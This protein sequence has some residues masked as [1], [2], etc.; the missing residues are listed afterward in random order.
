MKIVIIEDEQITADDLALSIRKVEPLAQIIAILKS[1]RESI[2]FFQDNSIKIDLIFSDIQLSD[3][4]SFEIFNKLSI[5]APII[6]CT[7]YDEYALNAFKV[8][9]IHYLLKPFTLKTVS[10]AIIKF[11]VLSSNLSGNSLQYHEI[12]EILKEGKSINQISI[13]VYQKDK[14]LPVP[15]NNIAIAYIEN[16]LTYIITF[17]QDKFPVNKSLEEIETL[18]GNRFF[19]AN[20]QYL[21]NRKVIK[22]STQYFARKILIN[23]SFP[24]ENRIIVSKARASEFLNWLSGN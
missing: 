20:R 9:G 22:D 17:N 18:T 8:N 15:L 7:A 23:L 5:N 21:V 10:E 14:I 13:L 11:K 12:L 24:F 6:F 16:E 3:G 4:L 1:V 19:R 2:D